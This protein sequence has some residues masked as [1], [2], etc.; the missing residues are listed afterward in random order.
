MAQSVER[1]LGK[2]EVGGSNPPSS[3][4]RKHFVFPFSFLLPPTSLSIFIGRGRGDARRL[5]I[6]SLCSLQIR[7]VAPKGNTLCSLFFL[8]R[9]PKKEHLSCSPL[10][11][12]SPFNLSL[13]KAVYNVTN[14]ILINKPPMISVAQCTPERKRATIINAVNIAIMIT[15]LHF[16]AIF[17]TRAIHCTIAV[18]ITHAMSN[19]VDEG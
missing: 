3:S 12:Q 17:F 1:V 13:Q 11:F 18:G 6:P 10:P 4:K 8:S 16:N 2:D 19:V 5:A 14:P 15:I 9:Q 7:L